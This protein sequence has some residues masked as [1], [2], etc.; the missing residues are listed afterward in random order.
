MITSAAQYAFVDFANGDLPTAGF[1]GWIMPRRSDQQSP[2]PV[3]MLKAEDIAF[4]VECVRD[5]VGAFKGLTFTSYDE[6]QPEGH[7]PI[8]TNPSSVSL[9]KL[10]SASQMRSIRNYTTN[11]LG[12]G[13]PHN[14]W[15]FL[16]TPLSEVYSFQLAPGFDL[17]DGAHAVIAPQFEGIWPATSQA[18]DF[19]AGQPV[20]AAPVGAV[21]DDAKNLV[22]PVGTTQFGGMFVG[23][24]HLYLAATEGSVPAGTDPFFGY[25]TAYS[26]S[27]W[28][29]RG[30]INPCEVVKVSR[31]FLSSANVW[32]LYLARY[33][34]DALP[35]GSIPSSFEYRAGLIRLSDYLTPAHTATEFHW[36]I[37]PTDGLRLYNR[38]LADCGWTEYSAQAVSYQGILPC[39]GSEIIIEGTPNGRTQWW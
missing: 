15:G 6:Y 23:P 19:D 36:A 34:V 30:Y 28:A 2:Y 4:L 39:F 13:F 12:R 35:D 22:R 21:F 25:K 5:K 10:I 38:I 8:W 14:G 37:T 11:Q 17:V 24:S 7:V 32:L 16:R 18:A 33:W 27:R 31:D 20:L 3:E 9:T 29:A 1:D 26:G